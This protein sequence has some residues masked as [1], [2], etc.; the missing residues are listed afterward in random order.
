MSEV[1]GRK[2]KLKEVLL[3]SK[4]LR[5]MGTKNYAEYAMRQLEKNKKQIELLKKDKSKT[6]IEIKKAKE[7]LNNSFGIDIGIF[8]LENIELASEPVFE[9]I[10]SY[11]DISAKEAENLEID[12]V[13]D[14]FK[15][16]FRAGL[17]EILFTQLKKVGE[18][19]LAKSNVQSN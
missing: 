10:G 13:I 5:G 18:D 12:K 16:M 6:E 15:N 17:P 1:I 19:F 8:V 9:L 11:N 14:T 7:D 2:I 4:I 3:I